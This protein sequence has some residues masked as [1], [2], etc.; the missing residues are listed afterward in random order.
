[1]KAA[2]DADTITLP[3]DTVTYGGKTA[4][5]FFVVIDYDRLFLSMIFSKNLA[6]DILQNF[7]MEIP[8]ACD[9]GLALYVA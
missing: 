1:M 2:A 4:K 5:A 8:F 9:F 7:D 3:A 6:N